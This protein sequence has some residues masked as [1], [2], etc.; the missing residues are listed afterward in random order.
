MGTEVKGNSTLRKFLGNKKPEK[1]PGPDPI[2]VK[3][4]QQKNKGS[5]TFAWN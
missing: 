3:I 1:G 2:V 5:T 4:P